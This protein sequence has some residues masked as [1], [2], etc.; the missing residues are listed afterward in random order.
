MPAATCFCFGSYRLDPVNERLWRGTKLVPLRP[1]PFALLRY[2]VAHAGRLVTKAELLRAL[3]PETRVSAEVLKGYIH[4]LRT[5]LGEKAE[6]PRFIET[7][8]RRGYRFMGTVTATAAATPPEE[9]REAPA[10]T[11]GPPRVPS[12]PAPEPPVIVGRE[13][14]LQQL[15]GWLA[16]ALGGR[17]QVVFVTGEAGIG[18]TTLVETF[19]AQAVI[20]R[21]CWLGLGQCI[22]HFGVGEAY[23]PV[24][25]AL[26]Q[27][28]RAPDHEHWRAR[29]EQQAPTWL[30]QMPALLSAAVQEALQRRTLGATRER[31]LRELAEALE[32]LTTEQPLV[33]VLEDLHW[34]DYATLDFLAFV[35][36]RSGPARLL[37]LGTYRPAEVILR[38]HPLKGVKQELQLH[39]Q[40]QELALELLPE[41]AVAAYLTARFPDHQVPAALVH[42]LY[43]RTDGNPL[44]LVTIV[45]ELLR[46]G[47]LV[48]VEKELVLNDALAGTLMVPATLHQMLEQQFERLSATEQQMLEA[49]S[50]AG[51]EFSAAAVAAGLATPVEEVEQ[52][53]A[54][55]ARRGQ[56]VRAMGTAEWPDGTVASRYGFLH[57]LYPEVLYERVTAAQRVSLHRRIGEREEQAYGARASELAAELAVHFEQGREQSKAVQYLQQA[58]QRASQRSAYVEAIGH[59]T[60]GLEL[61]KALPDSPE[62]AQQ[63]LTLQLALGDALVVVKGYA[64]Q[65]V[66]TIYTRARELCR[67]LGET[68]QLVS[69][70][71]RL[72]I[73]YTNRQELQ[74]TRELAEQMMRLAQ[75]VQDRSLLSLAHA[76]LGYI[77]Y[78]LG[79]LIAA[80]SHFEQGIA[81]YDFQ[82]DPRPTVNTVHHGVECLSYT[83]WTLWA[84]GYPE[85]ALKRN[86]EAMALAGE[87][88]FPFALTAALGCAALFHLLRREG[89]PA[90]ERAEAVIT[91]STEQGFASWLAIGT[92]VRGWALVERGQVTEGIAQMRESRMFFLAPYVLAEACGKVGQVEEGLT[93]LAKAMAVVDKTGMRVNHAELYR[94]KGELTLQQSR[95]H[96]AGRGEQRAESTEQGARSKRRL[97]NS[98]SL[99]A[100]SL[101]PQAPSGVQREAEECY[102]K[103]IDI[104]RKQQAK[105]RELRA[106]TSLA[107]LWQHQGKQHEAHRMLSEIYTWFTEGFD[108]KDLQEAKALLA[109]LEEEH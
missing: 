85:Q 12:P 55:L 9:R 104:A 28:C 60:K 15:Q 76:R 2:L 83:S 39:S 107:R 62:R 74:T 54:V 101:K 106:T 13:A 50:V 14:E 21:G 10:T 51:V 56:F 6:A 108:T 22:E 27:L 3:W 86:Y 84:L 57:A 26:G 32:V 25:A 5:V 100:P 36:R 61:L 53:C 23:L 58:G 88:A 82:K 71:D 1:K 69:V 24:L 90:R 96:R 75:S 105:S 41:I 20:P 17:R 67:Q 49:A 97:E 19:V 80:R 35:A 65:D 40:C 18:K 103:A 44:F 48:P 37:V 87:L 4:E 46:Q 79:E 38:E 72:A 81:L 16:Q 30:M 42:T 77:S 63:E 89:S 59:L 33:L 43:Q 102:L 94:L 98:S 8:A 66:E 31:M 52:R 47:L 7:V 45:E 34:S 93:V 109:A 92:M 64:D 95:E 99:Q 29:L 91:L 68:L 70:L 78:W 73:F 11:T